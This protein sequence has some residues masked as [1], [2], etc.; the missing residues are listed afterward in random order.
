MAFKSLV[1]KILASQSRLVSHSPKRSASVTVHFE[2]KYIEFD[3]VFPV[4]MK[5]DVFIIRFKS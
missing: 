3:Y 1:S 5:V 4:F 2:G